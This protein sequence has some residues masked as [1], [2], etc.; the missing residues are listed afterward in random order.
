MNSG[1]GAVAPI[2]PN[3]FDKLFIQSLPGASGGL[4]LLRY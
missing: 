2:G 3:Q 4:L 1:G